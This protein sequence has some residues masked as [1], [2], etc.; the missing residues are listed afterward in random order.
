[1]ATCIYYTAPV[2]LTGAIAG[3]AVADAVGR[4]PP[5]ALCCGGRVSAAF[6]RWS[7]PTGHPL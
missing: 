2:A 3:D 7:L 5:S 1:M 6:Q 4:C